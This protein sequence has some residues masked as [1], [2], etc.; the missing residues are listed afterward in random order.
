M[1]Q[2]IAKK[3]ETKAEICVK[4]HISFVYKGLE[5][6]YLQKRNSKQIYDQIK[7]KYNS[8]RKNAL[9]SLKFCFKKINLKINCEKKCLGAAMN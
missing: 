2:K 1:K 4:M 7:R 8:R 6:V 9:L 5:C 3:G